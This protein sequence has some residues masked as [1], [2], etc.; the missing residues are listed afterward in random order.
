MSKDRVVEA[1]INSCSGSEPVVLW[2]TFFSGD[3]CSSL[4]LVSVSLSQSKGHVV[5]TTETY[6]SK[7]SELWV[8]LL[9]ECCDSH[10]LVLT[11]S[12]SSRRWSVLSH[13][14]V[15][16][17]LLMSLPK[18]PPCIVS[19][20]AFLPALIGGWVDWLPVPS[21]REESQC[22]SGNSTPLSLKS[23]VYK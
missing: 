1:A 2:L 19:S 14:E 4:L 7:E 15:T 13:P 3:S 6:F 11:T 23:Y 10:P 16:M 20:V 21:A 18:P 5:G 22:C 17:V 8:E 12:C 9:V